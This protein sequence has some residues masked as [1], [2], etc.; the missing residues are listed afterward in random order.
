MTTKKLNA[1][2]K[3]RLKAIRAKLGKAKGD[4]RA[5]KPGADVRVAT[6]EASHDRLTMSHGPRGAGPLRP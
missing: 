4:V 6:H 5:G 3:K 2:E 1:R